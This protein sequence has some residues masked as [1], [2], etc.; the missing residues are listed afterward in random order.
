MLI[1]TM[2]IKMVMME[3]IVILIMMK[4]QGTV[5]F[6]SKLLWIVDLNQVLSELWM[7]RV[8]RIS[9]TYFPTLYLLTSV[10]FL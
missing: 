1:K 4:K 6:A 9:L 10:F 7:V 8:W 3:M 2:M 5:F